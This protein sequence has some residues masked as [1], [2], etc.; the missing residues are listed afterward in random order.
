MPSS[1]R[2]GPQLDM[3]QIEDFA[4]PL[5][6][7]RIRNITEHPEYA[8]HS[9]ML[10]T[11][12]YEAGREEEAERSRRELEALKTET[13]DRLDILLQ[14]LAGERVEFQKEN[15]EEILR[16]SMAIARR[17]TRATLPGNREALGE[18]LA[19][20]LTRLEAKSS[21]EILVNPEE[22]AMIDSLIREGLASKGGKGSYSIV[23]DPRLE[24]GDLVLEAR[25]GR[26][27][28]ICTEELDRLESHLIDHYRKKADENDLTAS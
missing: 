1:N 4:D 13:L 7:Q 27:E 10:R 23:A 11:R 15:A 16:L 5:G 9:E 25:E 22:V 2:A 21:F 28:A 12:A 17:V 6:W 14:K 20:C 19:A 26:I 24:P 3:D 8:A 18:I